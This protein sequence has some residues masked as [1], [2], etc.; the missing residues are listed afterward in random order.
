MEEKELKIKITIEGYE[1]FKELME[2]LEAV[3]FIIKGVDKA[4]ERIA[5]N[6]DK[7]K[8]IASNNEAK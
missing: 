5:S 8:K 7:M 3:S 2:E 4:F 1:E 6:A